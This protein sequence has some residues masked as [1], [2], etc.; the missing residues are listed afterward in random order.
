MR[1]LFRAVYTGTRPG[2]TPTIRAE[3]GWRG[4][5]E[6]KLGACIVGAYGETS[7]RYTRSEPQPPQPPQP[8]PGVSLRSTVASIFCGTLAVVS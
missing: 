6:P 4:R 3:K 1:L 2:L 7:R 8:P 5:R